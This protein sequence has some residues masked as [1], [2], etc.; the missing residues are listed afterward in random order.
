[1]EAVV[2]RLANDAE[3]DD[4]IT[5]LLAAIEQERAALV[6]AILE[7]RATGRVRVDA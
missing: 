5:R 6:A 2:A 4:I 3:R 7:A 1:M